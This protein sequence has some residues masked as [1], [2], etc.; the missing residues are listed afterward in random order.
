M[1]VQV[2]SFFFLFEMAHGRVACVRQ[3][4]ER[5]R[6]GTAGM[7]KQSS[8]CLRESASEIEEAWLLSRKAASAKS[9]HSSSSS[10]GKVQK[11]KNAKAQHKHER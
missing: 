11:G 5:E 9:K 4:R 1:E 10:K 7:Q 3:V 2:V 8:V 6:R